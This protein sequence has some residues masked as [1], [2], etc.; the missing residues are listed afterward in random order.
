MLIDDKRPHLFLKREDAG[1]F[2]ALPG[3]AERLKWLAAS[4][5]P[6]PRVVAQ[7][8]YEGAN[9]L[10]L[11]ALPGS[12]LASA[13][14]LPNSLRVEILAS[15]LRMLHEMDPT[16]CPFDETL[17]ASLAL[18]KRRMNSRLVDET[19]F[20][21]E[22]R[23]KSAAE[24]WP[25]LETEQPAITDLVVTHGDASL[26]NFMADHGRFNGFIDCGRLG[27]ADRYQDISRAIHSIRFNL[28]TAWVQPFFDLYGLSQPDTAKIQ[29]YDVL[30][31]FF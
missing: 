18:A 7:E 13:T 27:L 3:E 17:D 19:D 6:C 11:D 16:T 5:M 20:D 9:W 4:G 29:Y 1:P 12:D 10:L 28:G 23:G 15:A 8:R 22:R 24:L 30:E 14:F 25:Y 26:P 21:E 2:A 31:E